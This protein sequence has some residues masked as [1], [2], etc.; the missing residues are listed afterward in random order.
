V[1]Y[2]DNGGPMMEVVTTL[3]THAEAEGI[4]GL[5]LVLCERRLTLG[6]RSIQYFQ[7]RTS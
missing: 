4:A 3:I 1:L 5:Q 2:F 6:G 7:V